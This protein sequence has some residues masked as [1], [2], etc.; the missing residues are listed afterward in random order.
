[1]SA[2]PGNPQPVIRQ[3]THDDLDGVLA[4]ESAA[5][6]YPW[7]RQIFADCLI[8]GYLASVLD[9]GEGLVGYSILST[10]AAEAHILNLCVHPQWLRQGLAQQM[11]DHLL[12]YAQAL[13]VER[14][15]LEV[16]PSNDAA[17]CLY[18]KAGF[19]HL[20]LR[21]SYYRTTQGREDAL[22]LVLDMSG[23]SEID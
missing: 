5:Y 4:I 7:N 12:D 3:M 16:R 23:T 22:V 21:K 8:A 14:I 19:T 1:V 20:G 11:L 13:G 2:Q 10:A 9:S 15:F 6:E 18:E 17:I